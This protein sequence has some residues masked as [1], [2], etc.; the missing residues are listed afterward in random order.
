MNPA[1]FLRVLGPEPWRVAY[2]EPSVRPDDSR[3]GENPNRLQMHTQFQVILKPDPVSKRELGPERERGGGGREGSERTKKTHLFFPNFF[4]PPR[5]L[6][7]KQGNPQELFLGSLAALGI[8]VRGHDVR[9]VEDNWENPALGAWG[10][11]W[12]V[13]LDGQEVT[14]FTYFQA[15]GGAPL[16]VPAVEITYGLERIVTAL[17][18]VSHFTEMRY[19]PGSADERAA[20]SSPSSP[21]PSSSDGS[22]PGLS[23]GEMLLQNEFEWSVFNLDAADVPSQRAAFDLHKREAERLLEARLPLPAYAQILKMSHAFNVLDARGAVSVSDRAASFAAMRGMARGVSALWL[24]RREELGWPLLRGAAKEEALEKAAA[25]EKGAAEGGGGGGDKKKKK[26]TGGDAS[27]SASSAPAAVVVAPPAG[28]SLPSSP[29]D[30]LLEIGCEELPPDDADAA[31]EQLLSK[32][33]Q[34]LSKLGLEGGGEG[35]AGGGLTVDATP[36]RIVARV[37]GLPA[38]T[39][40]TQERLRGPPAKAAFE[41]GGEDGAKKPTRALLGFCAKNGVEV[42]SV[43]VGPEQGGGPGKGGVDYCWASVTSGGEPAA[44]ALERSLPSLLSQISFGRS[45][46]WEAGGPS[47]SRPVRWVAALHGAAPLAFAA[48]GATSIPS[49]SSSSGS[50]P[51]ASTKGIRDGVEAPWLP[52]PDASSYDG[53]MASE[54]VVLSSSE[55]EGAVRS[56]AEAAARRAGGRL[57][58]GAEN[59]PLVEGLVREVARLVEAPLPLLG[60]FDP[61]FLDLPR[62]VLV[63]VMRKHQR[64]FPVEEEAG[65]EGTGAE[66][67]LLPAFVMVA[68]GSKVDPATVVAGNEA[69]LRARFEDARFFYS[70]DCAKALA[71]FVPELEK[72]AFHRELG[73]LLDKQRRVGALLPALATAAPTPAFAFSSADL[74]V[75]SKASELARADAATSVVREM[76]SLAG[77]MGRHYALRSGEATPAVAD[78]IYEAALPRSSGDVLPRSRAGALLAVADRLDSIVGLWSVGGAPTA[79][80][81]PYGLR[82]AAL[83]LLETAIASGMR[84]DLASAARSAA[85]LQPVEVSEESLAGATQFVLRRL[86]Q[87]LV[88]RQLPVEAVRGALGGGRG[89]DPALAARTAEELAAALEEGASSASSPLRVAVEALSRPARITR[90]AE[91][92]PA[93]LAVDESLFDCEEERALAAALAATRRQLGGEDA[94]AA[95]VGDFLRA[96]GD[97]L[98]GP[99]AAFFDSVFVMCED[100]RVK[101][102]RLALLR[103]VAGLSEGVV[104]FDELPGF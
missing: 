11:G 5:N 63:T 28:R 22:W 102:N 93:S 91:M 46:R 92:P 89:G 64:Y 44:E 58:S 82:R 4:F 21:P 61:K 70:A 13:W 94:S 42:S 59:S 68:N 66:K 60:S 85:A 53:L 26:K 1:T 47:F 35:G 67:R 32:L 18:G 77:V 37:R 83:G 71:D 49:S 19:S 17:Q 29:A 88:D 55:R 6:F 31:R 12:E 73:S 69:V 87:L 62:D 39:R 25:A 98:P 23:Y 9:F 54:G 99:V 8:D 41:D 96:V 34:L 27:A 52:L 40:V 33:G 24:A 101:N 95:S 3:Y 75:A 48:L 65:E 81:D 80:A 45:M 2:A 10:L 76:T 43:E 78:A 56:G 30:F 20:S 79:S 84:L 103:E 104:K 7:E 36:R 51:S 50:G 90:S 86:E 15:V 57:P 16:A 100:P 72:V 74:E 38:A 97:H 14:Q